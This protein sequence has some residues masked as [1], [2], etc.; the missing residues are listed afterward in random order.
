[1]EERKKRPK[2]LVMLVVRV[3][4]QTW[5]SQCLSMPSMDLALV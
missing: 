4:V 2:S 1:M 3:L 5:P